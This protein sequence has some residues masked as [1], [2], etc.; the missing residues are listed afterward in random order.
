[1]PKENKNQEDDGIKINNDT[2]SVAEFTKRPIPTEEEVEE[3]EEKIG[4]VTYDDMMD[5]EGQEKE[6]E[7]EESLNEIYQDD[8]GD[9]VDDPFTYSC[10]SS[11]QFAENVVN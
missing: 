4:E 5:D 9:M 3:F 8:N 6:E 7:M 11:E 1:M 2:S 10:H